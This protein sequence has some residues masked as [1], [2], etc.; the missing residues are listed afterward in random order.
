MVYDKKKLSEAERFAVKMPRA[1][2]FGGIS[3]FVYKN[4]VGVELKDIWYSIWHN[5][6]FSG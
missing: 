2:L 4:N 5:H 6:C 1:Y 3:A